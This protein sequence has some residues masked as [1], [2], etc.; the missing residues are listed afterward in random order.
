MYNG[1]YAIDE[2]RVKIGE[3]LSTFPVKKATL[4]GSYAKGEATEKSDIDLVID[5]EG[6]IRGLD[7]FEVRADLEEKLNKQVD[8]IEQRTIIKDGIAEKE[9]LETGVTIYEA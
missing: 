1:V 2:L 9:I 5:S 8:L 6:Q 4:F 7:F 3:I